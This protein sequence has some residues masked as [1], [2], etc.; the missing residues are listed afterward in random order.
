MTKLIQSTGGH[1][2][3]YLLVILLMLSGKTFSQEL[4]AEMNIVPPSPDVAAINKFLDVPVSHYSGTPNITIPIFKIHTPQLSL[5]ISLNYH[6]SGWKVEEHASWLGAGWALNAGGS[7]NRTVRGLPDEYLENTSGRKGYL[8]NHRLFD[9]TGGVDHAVLAT[10][11]PAPNTNEVQETGAP[12]ITADSVS[13]GLLDLEPDLFSYNFPGGSGKFVLNRQGVPVKYALDDVAFASHSFDDSNNLPQLNGLQATDYSWVLTGPDGTQYTFNKAERTY[14]TSDCGGAS[15]YALGATAEHQSAWK[16]YEISN[17]GDWIRFEYVDETQNY[18][19]RVSTSGQF[20]VG[21]SGDASRKGQT[22]NF[23][24]CENS[25]TT[26][27]KRLSR[28]TSSNGF[29]VL[30][31]EG[32]TRVDLNGSKRL[33]EIVIKRDGVVIKKYKLSNS[34]YFG[35]NSK[36]KLDAVTEMSASGGTL[37]GYVFTYHNPGGVP[38][39]SSKAQD[40]WGFYNE[41]NSN[42]NLIPRFR[43]GIYDVNQTSTVD[44]NPSLEGARTGVLSSIQYPTGGFTHFTYELHDYWED[45]SDIRAIEVEKEANASGTSGAPDSETVDFVLTRETYVTINAQSSDDDNFGYADIKKYNENLDQYQV[46]SAAYSP[47]VRTLLSAGKYRLIAHSTGEQ[48]WI[49]AEYELSHLDEKVNVTV[50][51]LRIKTIVF[52]DP[53]TNS[54]ITKSFNYKLGESEFSSGKLFIPALMGGEESYRRAGYLVSSEGQGDTCIED[55]D[56]TYVNVNANSIVPTGIFQG[57]HIGYS[58]VKE[59]YGF[60]ST[61]ATGSTYK[62][63]TPTAQLLSE[64]P[65]NGRDNGMI[66]HEFI[67]DQANNNFFYPLVLGHDVSHRN[68]KQLEQTMYGK[69]GGVLVPLSHTKYEYLEEEYFGTFPVE[70]TVLKK[71]KS[72]F[73]F[74]L[75]LDDYKSSSYI[76]KSRRH[77][78]SKVISSQLDPSGRELTVT[79]NHS[80]KPPGGVNSPPSHLFLTAKDWI[81]SQGKKI[82]EEYTRDAQKPALVTKNETFSDQTQIKGH[83]VT[84]HGTLPLTVSLWD[85]DTDSYYLR[86]VNTFD[87]NLLTSKVSDPAIGT[88]EAYIWAYEKKYPVASITGMSYAELET[89][90]GSAT[91]LAIQFGTNNTILEGQLLSVKSQLP[92]GALMKII[93]HD[94]GI[95]VVKEISPNGLIAQYTY[96]EFN[97]LRSVRDKDGN[98]LKLYEYGYQETIGN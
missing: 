94:P 50:G 8:H 36:L 63:N 53:I 89:L 56:I 83:E 16:L 31:N 5:P 92:K 90:V 55:T 19:Q 48:N 57:G 96:D 76:I 22:N 46:I 10:I 79:V 4:P 59:F 34:S 40:Y 70:G 60:E 7:V 6:A 51:G 69:E 39:M 72:H 30:F 85:R 35:S 42:V 1:R 9:N 75:D 68:G 77:Y 87:N 43:N 18:D 13:Q 54:T 67:N 3:L 23:S 15:P 93:L 2:C 14:N 52:S 95:G 65:A 64:I 38:D 81:D 44:R 73:C 12:F 45:N 74:V 61:T 80:Y 41:A 24:S 97:R 66:V 47:G 11:D 32:A 86:S 33:D 25:I 78:L 29:E 20:I 58:E 62:I 84:Y 27:A 98:I 82:K 71:V 49:K 17:N 88:S 28:I 37:P 26:K 91:L 21:F